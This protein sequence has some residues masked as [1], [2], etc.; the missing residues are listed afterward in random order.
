MLRWNV[1]SP[2]SPTQTSFIYSDLGELTSRVTKAGEVEL[3]RLDIT[4]VAG[5]TSPHGDLLVGDTRY[6]FDGKGRNTRVGT[7]EWNPHRETT[8][9]A[10]DLPSEIKINGGSQKFTFQ[11]DADHRRVS[12]KNFTTPVAVYAGDLYEKHDQGS[13]G[14]IRHIF[15]IHGPERVVAQF[16]IKVWGSPE[17]QF[18]YLHNDHLG[19]V[20][21]AVDS[22]GNALTFKYDP[23]GVQTP[24][25]SHDLRRGFTFHE[26][27]DDVTEN[28]D[29]PGLINMKGRVYD[30]KIARFVTAD[31]L[32]SDPLSSQGYNRYAYVF[33]NPLAFVDPSGFQAGPGGQG[34]EQQET[35][36]QIVQRFAEY[37]AETNAANAAGA[38]TPTGSASAGAEAAAAAAA[39][40]GRA[41]AA[42]AASAAGAAMNDAM[43]EGKVL[44]GRWLIAAARVASPW[45]GRAAA[46]IGQ[47]LLGM[48]LGVRQGAP[49]GFLVPTPGDYRSGPA[50]YGRAL[51]MAA[52][53]AVEMFMGG[54]GMM[55]GG[56]MA[57]AGAPTIVGV[58]AGAGVAAAGAAVGVMGARSMAGAIEALRNA[59]ASGEDS[60]GANDDSQGGQSP[61]S[62]GPQDAK[63]PGMPGAAEGYE[64]P[65][66]WD[67]QLIST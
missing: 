36:E 48:G 23:F 34:Y 64:P 66:K 51:G 5:T 35:H 11:Y 39:D 62:S 52:I 32:V 38:H 58:G 15:Y 63:A 56:A 30:P 10:F 21:T 33:N 19:S 8:Y 41:Q 12:K 65:R 46:P 26:E 2:A 17:E 57:V 1:L 28:A 37:D 16:E 4:S 14:I 50:A 40:Q 29:D 24:A 6:S 9:S 59:L 25:G 53:G 49:G 44:A 42:A 3:S 27:D 54:A 47:F 55:G 45:E 43:Q 31:P 18:F 22:Q 7:D 20:E 67:G 60:G 61:S 13:D